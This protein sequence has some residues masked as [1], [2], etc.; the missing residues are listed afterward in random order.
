MFRQRIRLRYSIGGDKRFLSH[1]DLMRVWLRALRRAELPLRLSE[2]FHVRPKVSFALAKS[3]GIASESEWFEFELADWVNPEAV[4]RALAPR[5]PEGIAIVELSVVSPGD[6]AVATRAVYA[7]ELQQLPE[8]ID[9]RIAGLLARAEIV[10]SRGDP[11][12][13]RRVDIRPLLE[14]VRR[15]D[16]RLV[17][18][19]RCKN[20]GTLKPEEVLRELGLGGEEIARGL[21]TRTELALAS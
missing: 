10:V 18:A 17:I 9:E 15:E 12:S 7:A 13:P 21:I 8:D 16:S 4:Y 19:A 2:G 14:S 20:E 3:V 5:L 11:E 1:H 6:R